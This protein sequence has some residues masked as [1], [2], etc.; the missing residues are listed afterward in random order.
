[1]GA[2]YRYILHHCLARAVAEEPGPTTLQL[3][4]FSLGELLDERGRK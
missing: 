2:I 4:V 1:M 3:A